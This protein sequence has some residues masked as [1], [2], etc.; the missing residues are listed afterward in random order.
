MGRPLPWLELMRLSNL[1]TVVGNCMVGA[2]AGRLG[3][4][5]AGGQ[6]PVLAESGLWWAVLAV[7]LCYIG[8]MALNDV[9]DASRDAVAGRTRPIPAGRI[10]WGHALAFSLVCLMGGLAVLAV[11][12]G[13]EAFMAGAVLVVLIMGYDLLHGRWAGAVV[14]MGLC[15]AAVYVVAAAAVAPG[16]WHQAPLVL[17]VMAGL[18]AV[19]TIGITVIARMEDRPGL[20]AR[21]W[22]A[23]GMAL[24]PLAAMTVAW[25]RQ[26]WMPALVAAVL[27]LVWLGRSARCALVRPP[28]TRAAVMGWLS[29]LCL[30]DAFYLGLLEQRYAAALAVACFAL[31]AWAHRRISGT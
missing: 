15:R 18:V 25:P 29:G 6:G 24:L 3:T 16:E 2:A 21:R 14:L 10:R 28:R 17:G 31:T 19:Y 5:M 7:A 13:W 1:P 23:V 26:Q 12:A 9:A 22:L 8:G 30:I 11:A 20:D 4:E 27:M